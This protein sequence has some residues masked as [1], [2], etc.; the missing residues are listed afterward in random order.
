MI[1]DEKTIASFTPMMQSYLNIKKDFPDK[2]VFFRL[3][4]FYELFF[5]DAKIASSIFDLT[6]T[7]RGS[8]TENP[9]PMAGIPFHALDNYLNKG[10]QK[11]YSIVIC[12]QVGEAVKGG[13]LMKREVSRIL[14]P[15]TVLDSNL[16]SSQEEVILL[17]AFRKLAFTYISWINL[18]SGEAFYHTLENNK[19]V[20]FI[21]K[22]QPNE[23]L[24]AKSQFDYFSIC[25]EFSKIAELDDWEFDNVLSSKKITEYLGV[26]YVYQYGI[27]NDKVIPSLV[28]LFNY[29]KSTQRQDNIYLQNIKSY[30][31]SDYLEIDQN[32]F[33]QLEILDSSSGNSLFNSMNYCA[34]S[35]GSRLLKA[36]LKKPIQDKDILKYRLK[37]VE[38]LIGSNS[39]N[40]QYTVW[41]NIVSDFCDIERFATKI[42]YKS[43][44]PKELASLRNTLRNMNKLFLWA[45]NMPL[46]IKGVFL[47]HM[48]HDVPLKLLEQYLLEEPNVWVRDGGIIA[49]GIDKE[50]DEARALQQGHSKFLSKFEIEEKLKTNIPNLKVEYNS[51]QGFFISISNS[52]VNKVP[53]HYIRK[54]TL[55]NNER[56]T[57]KELMEYEQKALSANEKALIRERIIYDKLLTSLKPYINALHKQSKIIAE[58]DVLACF[59]KIASEHNWKC[60]N[61][62]DNNILT[63]K[64]GIHPVV[65]MKLKDFVPN[66]L[67][68]NQNINSLIITGPNMGGKSTYM[69]QIA[70]ICLIAHLGSYV[71]AE[72]A[73]IPYI[74]NIFTRIGANDDISSGRSTFMVE[75]SEVA[76]ILNN[77]TSNSLVLLDE[78]GRGTSTYDGLSL[79]WNIL[80]H[81]SNHT[82]S[83]TICATH[84]IEMTTLPNDYS[85]IKNVH[86]SAIENEEHELIFTHK[87]TEGFSNRSYG[88]QVAQL[89]GV[90]KT[91]LTQSRKKLQELETQSNK[92]HNNEKNL[93][94]CL[95]LYELLK[96]LDLNNLTPLESLIFLQK[97]KNKLA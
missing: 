41:Q 95:D 14:T 83:F 20:E 71:P 3:G 28:A 42:A 73:S 36:W 35:M 94:N 10:L 12:E 26:N 44:R 69:R 75:M 21:K 89:A 51:A 29:I 76:Y 84:Y 27:E 61:F 67:E 38:F 45:Q 88:I 96:N 48:T 50:L 4:D 8:T 15:G 40:N 64:N 7:Q 9:I 81:L 11:G 18:S 24:V 19:S 70:L 25:S 92:K 93:D 68:L 58:F 62:N 86:V 85:N 79:A 91:I 74:D 53:D 1:F 23:I 34:T 57:T 78:L 56:F 39:E 17:S 43:I 46:E 2:L 82:K 49:D 80:T 52:H 63:I 13:G 59:A 66:D 55:K 33:K 5:D 97:L 90:P 22:I 60:P 87:V 37:R 54:Q 30:N 77:A 32:S 31:N 72:Y 47:S 65:S 6:L 16:I